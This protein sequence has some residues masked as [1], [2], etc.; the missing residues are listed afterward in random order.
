MY[1]GEG[2]CLAQKAEEI[3]GTFKYVKTRIE[4]KNLPPP[5]TYNYSE[6]SLL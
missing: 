3:V 2:V 6:N 4:L 1:T 5:T